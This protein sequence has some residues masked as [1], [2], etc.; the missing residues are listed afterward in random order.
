MN[1]AQLTPSH[2]PTYN[3]ARAYGSAEGVVER[4]ALAG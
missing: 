1:K 4:M 3:R 2:A